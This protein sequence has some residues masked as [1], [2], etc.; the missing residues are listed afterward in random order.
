[1]LALGP[2]NN[3]L[4]QTDLPLPQYGEVRNIALFHDSIAA[5]GFPYVFWL[6]PTNGTHSS[7]TELYTGPPG[8]GKL[9]ANGDELYWA[10]NTGGATRYGKTDV[11]GDPVWSGTGPDLRINAIAVDDTGA[12]WIGG[13]TPSGGLLVRVDP[14]GT[15][16]GAYPQYATVTDVETDGD[17]VLWTGR[18]F[19]QQPHTYLIV[20]RNP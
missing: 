9:V 11:N 1:M 6:R 5:V 20:G 12:L 4:W 16:G 13:E 15:F 17:R 7:T 8:H 18:T 2:N 14:D 3:L 10:V 19:P